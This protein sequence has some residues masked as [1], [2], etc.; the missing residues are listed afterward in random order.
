VGGSQKIYYEVLVLFRELAAR[1][2]LSAAVAL[3]VVVLVALHPVVPWFVVLFISVIIAGDGWCDMV[4][5][6]WGH[7]TS[8]ILCRPHYQ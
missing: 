6:V 2:D 8:V 1:V 5:L 4:V 7:L 3:A